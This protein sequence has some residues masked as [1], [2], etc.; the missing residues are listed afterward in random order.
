MV[1]VNHV[2][3]WKLKENVAD[4]DRVKAD[5]REGLERLFGV[6]SG[7][8]GMSVY[9]DGLPGSTADVMLQMVFESTEAL[10]EYLVHPAHVEFA[11]TKV[12]PFIQT[13]T[14]FDY[15]NDYGV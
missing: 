7:L 13:R 14:C 4:K 2:V 1:E 11:N 9:T 12:H 15:M 6:V 8:V 3:C 5:I 10:K